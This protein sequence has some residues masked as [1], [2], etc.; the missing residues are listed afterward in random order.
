MAV[1]SPRP[2]CYACLPA[3]SPLASALKSLAVATRLYIENLLKNISFYLL[4]LNI[5]FSL[6]DT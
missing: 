4:Y 6:S 2:R 1:T 3:G 5:S